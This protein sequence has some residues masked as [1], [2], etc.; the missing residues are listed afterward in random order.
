MRPRGFPILLKASIATLR[1][2]SLCTAEGAR[3]LVR[4][5]EGEKTKFSITAARENS[6]WIVT[7]TRIHSDIASL[8]IDQNAK[9]EVAVGKK[10]IDF[11]HGNPGSFIYQLLQSSR[12]MQ[13]AFQSLSISR[14]IHHEPVRPVYDGTC[15]QAIAECVNR[16]SYFPLHER[17]GS[18]FWRAIT[19]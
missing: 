17:T 1:S 4:P 14:Y 13:V 7:D 15:Q 9:R 10:R 11:M 16:K 3:V 5:T 12:I 2:S 8:F 18:S 6:R 19:Q